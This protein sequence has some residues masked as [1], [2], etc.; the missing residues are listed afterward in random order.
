MTVKDM[1]D[2]E[3][4]AYKVDNG[5]LITDVKTMSK[6][7]DQNMSKGYVITQVD[8]KKIDS[9]DEFD[10]IIKSKKGKAILLKMVDREGTSR[11]VGLEIPE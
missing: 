9:V 10:E 2:D 4:E 8:K 11:L 3:K 7:D 1:T 5:V 6:A